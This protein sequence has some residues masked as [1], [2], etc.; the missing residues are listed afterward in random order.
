MLRMVNILNFQDGVQKLFEPRLCTNFMIV[1]FFM[2]TGLY[3]FRRFNMLG[4]INIL[5]FL[6]D[7]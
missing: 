5:N 7:A 6:D 1:T 4:M 3:N 2:K